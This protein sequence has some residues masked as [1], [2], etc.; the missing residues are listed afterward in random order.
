MY[1]SC[2]LVRAMDRQITG[3]CLSLYKNEGRHGSDRMV[4]GITTTYAISAYHHCE[5]EFCSGNT[6]LYD[7][8]CQ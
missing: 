2:V 1:N 5:F 4:V 6:T 7:K 8:V 3:N